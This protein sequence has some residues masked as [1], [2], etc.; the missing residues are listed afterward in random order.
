MEL[1]EVLGTNETPN[2]D[3]ARDLVEQHGFRSIGGWKSPEGFIVIVED[4][5]RAKDRP[6]SPR[7]YRFSQAMRQRWPMLRAFKVQYRKVQ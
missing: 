2:F 5:P 3:V 1:F 6:L 7:R 4:D